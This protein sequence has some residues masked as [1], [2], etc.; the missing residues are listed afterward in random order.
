MPKGWPFDGAARLVSRLPAPTGTGSG[1]LALELNPDPVGYF[2]LPFV[3]TIVFTLFT[4]ARQ[5]DAKH[6]FSIRWTSPQCD[7]SAEQAKILAWCKTHAKKYQGQAEATWVS[8]CINDCNLDP[9]CDT[10][11]HDNVHWQLYVNMKLRKRVEQ[12]IALWRFEFKGSN[13]ISYASKAG[14]AAL[15]SYVMKDESYVHGT[16]F[17][18][19]EIY[20][21]ADLPAESALRPFQKDILAY[22]EGPWIKREILWIYD[23]RGNS[24]KTDT[25]KWMGHFK[26]AWVSLWDT[27]ANIATRIFKN[28]SS[29]PKVC[30]FN[31]TKQKPHAVHKV[32]LYTMI[33]AVKD[34][35]VTH[36][37]WEGGQVFFNPPHVVVLA[38]E[39][40]SMAM[41]A[42]N[43]FKVKGISRSDWTLYDYYTNGPASGFA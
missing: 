25:A 38:N 15:Q 26:G 6:I 17:C 41:L 36:G 18:D 34:G 40:P 22:C 16:R 32:D 27:A 3:L 4:M 23:S 1:A 9:M 8:H 31:L 39:L 35:M 2:W 12:V 19:H 21:G 13:S 20:T 37:K 30:I 10:D 14:I 33:E 43:R 24:G 7:F 42:E 11:G 28:S 29:P 5:Q